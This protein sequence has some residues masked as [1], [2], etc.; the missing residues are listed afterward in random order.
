MVY[1]YDG[2]IYGIKGGD[3]VNVLEQDSGIF[4]GAHSN[5]KIFNVGRDPV[6]CILRY[7]TKISWIGNI[8]SAV[9]QPGE[10]K[11]LSNGGRPYYVTGVKMQNDTN[12]RVIASAHYQNG[13]GGY[14]PGGFEFDLS[15]NNVLRE[16]VA[17]GIK[18]VPY[19][20]AGLS[21][22]VKTF[23]PEH[24]KSVWEQ[25]RD[26]VSILVDQ[27]ILDA[28]NALLSGDISQ[29]KSR[30][31]TVV[32]EIASKGN[33][34]VHYMNIAQDLIGFENKFIF[35]QSHPD[36]K[37]I[38][39]SLLPMYSYVIHMK[40]LFYLI[41]VDQRDKIGLSN[42]N[43]EDIK[44]YANKLLN[45]SDNGAFAYI[46]KVYKEQVDNC[47]N[48]VDV[49]GFYNSMMSTRCY[50]AINGLEYVPIWDFMLKN[51]TTKDP[52][53][54]NDAISY[55]IYHGR[56]TSDLVKVSSPEDQAEPLTPRLIGGKRNK[57]R[58]V[59]VYI[60]R[61]NSGKGQ[62]K[63]GG[64]KVIFEDGKEY[65][66]GQS[67]IENKTIE[68]NNAKLVKL[69]VWGLGA[70][71]L[72]TFKFSDGREETVGTNDDSRG[73]VTHF[74]L[75]KHHIVGLVLANDFSSTGGQANNIAV[76]Y[77]LNYD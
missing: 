61:I 60:W 62:P 45:D 48:T 16:L 9:V 43:V 31:Q 23:W 4:P 38:N 25:V 19:V 26:N 41:G 36:Y 42:E 14:S 72:I 24:K 68:W 65:M 59:V 63:I 5:S 56:Q 15:I 7:G 30:I 40:L 64:L 58:S 77:Q 29:Y 44:K 70:L 76:S 66:M 57:I 13:G 67:N 37:K 33:A 73:E 27:K 54:Y 55:S 34:S 71:D 6:Y 12:Q 53:I 17:T 20:G 50:V 74:E 3:H 51:P 10:T 49:R 2:G 35:S 8:T 21:F 18:Y 39:Y 22:L 46:K 69:S 1:L 32:E 75:E 11:I 52:K 47:Y 28:I